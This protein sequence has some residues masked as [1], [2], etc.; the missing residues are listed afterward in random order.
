M[1]IL[2]SPIGPL[3]KLKHFKKIKRKAIGLFYGNQLSYT[4]NSH[5]SIWFV[6]GIKSRESCVSK[7]E[8]LPRSRRGKKQDNLSKKLERTIVASDWWA[9]F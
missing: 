9:A 3:G 7:K 8:I 2:K 5:K 6:S 4:E 1:K